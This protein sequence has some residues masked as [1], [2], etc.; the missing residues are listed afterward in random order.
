MKKRFLRQLVATLLL[1]A[2]W[3]SS[4]M[5]WAANAAYPFQDPGQPLETRVNDLVSRLT[6]AEK[7]AFFHQYIPAISRLGIGPFRTGTEALHGIA[8]LGKATVFPQATGLG[9]TWNPELL[10][11]IGSAVGD[12]ARGFHGQDPAGNG[13]SLWAP[14]VD[15]ARDPRAGRFEESYGEDPYLVGQLALAYCTGLKGDDPFYYKTIPTLK[16]FYAYNQEAGRDT[17]SVT[18]DARNSHEYYLKPFEVPIVAGAAKSLMTSYNLVNGVP[19]TV[20]PEI[21]TLVK[22]EWAEGKDFFVVTDA[23]APAN[24]TGSQGYYADAAQAHAGMIGAGI[25]S[26]TQDGSDATNTI[27]HIQQALDQGLIT[28]TQ[29]D[30][31]VKNILRVR[32]HTGEFDPDTANPYAGLG[33]GKIGAPDHAALALKAAR[34]QL[35]LLKNSQ[36]LLPLDA[37]K[38]RRVAV[39]GPL[40]DQVF[41]DFYSAPFLY[42]RSVLDG[43][44]A[45]LGP[46]RIRFDRGVNRIALQ[47]LVNGK[48]VTAPSDGGQLTAE[49]EQVG[50]GEIFE[51]YDFGWGQYLFRAQA[52]DGYLTGNGPVT[53]TANAPGVQ[54]D[55][56]GA[57]EWFTYQNF[58]METQS[59]GACAL[60]NYQVSHW[61]TGLDGGKYVTVAA[62]AP[63]GLNA[64]S[65]TVGDAQKFRPVVV[66]EG[67][68]EAAQAA[69]GV[70]AAI[71]VVGNQPMLNGR[72]TLDRTDIV[73]PPD[74][75]RLI[76]RVA[77]V[78]PNTIVV[79]ISS[80][81]MAIGAL[82]DHPNIKAIL[83]ASHGGQEEG[84]AIADALFGDYAPA[85]RLNATWYRSAD[86][87][88]P[89]TDYDI[90]GGKRTYLYFDGDPLYPFGYGLTY[91]TFG[92]RDL[93]ITPQRL[94]VDGQVEVRVT[95][96]NTGT[97]AS[98]EVVQLYI[99]DIRASVPTPG[100]ALRGFQ[101][102][103]LA[104]GEGKTVS[105]TVPVRE[106]AYWD[107]TRNGFYVEPGEFEVMVGRSAEDIQLRKI[108]WVEGAKS[109]K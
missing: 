105:F 107:A 2:S 38:I 99:R 31:G 12:E 102:I 71:V 32:F 80:Y 83:Y 21:N 8:W 4:T 72:E 84:T 15:L 96:E 65:A 57:Q 100:K 81:P 46:E 23:Y 24:L 43:V 6:L 7:I 39:I 109:G 48:Y 20:A 33:T 40:A 69:C 60:Y 85:G 64:D 29:I 67:L 76:K 28:E 94:T 27:N 90:I 108:F 82:Q 45:K 35:V 36:N 91:T 62:E 13:L 97:R 52:N 66:R 77:A 73:L 56:A 1:L 51:C 68:G 19:C 25:D 18:L 106:L 30:Q 63:Y 89:I 98:D 14:V 10:R 92:Y 95:V 75:E 53:N 42:T 101:R 74:Q 26:M 86:Q 93:A 22:G 16:H 47:A 78:N 34:E 54:E 104:P 17:V 3:A 87:L 9:C 11:E 49:A 88:P 61:D 50:A 44:R 103:H 55:R 58:N 79:I 41:T 59:D 37:A 70:D 5:I